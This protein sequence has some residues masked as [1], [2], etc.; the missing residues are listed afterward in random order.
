M[1]L[2]QPDVTPRALHEAAYKGLLWLAQSTLE[3]FSS[4]ETQCFGSVRQNVRDAFLAEQAEHIHDELLATYPMDLERLQNL[5]HAR[6]FIDYLSYCSQSDVLGRRYQ[7]RDAVENAVRNYGED[8]FWNVWPDELCGDNCT[9][10]INYYHFGR[11]G[12]PMRHSLAEV[13]ESCGPKAL[14]RSRDISEDDFEQQIYF[15]THWIYALSDYGARPLCR[16]RHPKI[17]A[18]LCDV[19]PDAFEHGNLE[20]LGEVIECLKLFGDMN[21]DPAFQPG[22]RSILKRQNPD[23]SWGSPQFSTVIH[24]TWCCITALYDYRPQGNT[25]EWGPRAASDFFPIAATTS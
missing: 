18:F 11:L 2:G 13:V 9:S 1:R 10:L 17:Y 19:F 21:A 12:L 8:F 4:D 3:S 20:T 7:H 6:S 24:T 22:L 5:E 23:G 15:V 14:N 25:G 16:E